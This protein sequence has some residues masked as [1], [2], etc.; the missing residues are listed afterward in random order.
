MKMSQ[1]WTLFEWSFD[2]E[3]SFESFDECYLSY[4]SK[5]QD[6]PSI[7]LNELFKSR[8]RMLGSFPLAFYT[9]ME[10]MFQCSGMCRPA[11]FY[12]SL[13]VSEGYPVQ[14]CVQE[15]KEFI[16]DGG[17]N[18]ARSSVATGVMCLL[19]F[20]VHLRFYCVRPVDEKDVRVPVPP[21]NNYY[22]S[23]QGVQMQNLDTDPNEGSGI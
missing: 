15:Y 23:N 16:D 20:L 18:F 13:P 21:S 3:N 9:K 8:V 12:H 5:A 4:A 11:L 14:T 17:I 1:N 10:E 6:D 19:I 22:N 7:D 2:R